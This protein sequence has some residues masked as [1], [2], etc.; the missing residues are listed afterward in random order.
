M[1]LWSKA[2][3]R[4]G[5]R[6]RLEPARIKT[7]D[8]M[9]TTPSTDAARSSQAFALTEIVLVVAQGYR[10]ELS[11]APADPLPR[12][13]TGKALMV[14]PL[15]MPFP[16]ILWAM[17][18]PGRG[19]VS[20]PGPP[21]AEEAVV[22][23]VGRV[24]GDVGGQARN[25]IP[26]LNGIARCGGRNAQLIAREKAA[27]VDLV[28]PGKLDIVIAIASHEMLLGREIMVDA[29]YHKVAGDWSIHVARKSQD[30]RSIAQALA[31]SGV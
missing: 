20:R 1:V 21:V 10:E 13:Y 22:K 26:V 11:P 17:D 3:E 29:P 30:I 16:C 8:A 15:S 28:G 6:V 9:D 27:N 25:Q 24:V 31:A 14:P 4:G 7:C 5:C 18:L 12:E 2:L 23:V 19:S